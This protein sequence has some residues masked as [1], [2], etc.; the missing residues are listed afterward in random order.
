MQAYLVRRLFESALILL[1]ITLVTFIL[2]YLVPADPARQIAGRSA[3]AETVQNIRDQLGLNDPF[4][5][6][7]W[8]YLT[9]LLQ[10]DMG[11]SYLQRAEVS[12]LIASRLPASLLLMLAAIV[13][14][15]IFG[16]TIGIVAALRRNRPAD[17][18]LMIFS[19]VSISAPQFVIGILLLYV[20]AVKLGWFPIGG[21]GTFSHVVLPA[22][23]LGFL[24]A[25]WYSRM[26]RS[27]MID[28]LGQ[29]FVRTAQAKGLA[30]GRIILRHVIPNAILPIIAMIGIDIGLFMSGIV[31]VESVFG[32][33]GIGQL[34]WQAI[35]RVD[36]PVIMGVTMV[37]ATA[38]VLG[39]LLADFVAPMIDPRIK[40]K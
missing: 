32:W 7:Y 31:V 23:T 1:G 4:F 27:S 5:I 38:I 39:N 28:V 10:G 40:T 11:R 25:G 17:H 26:M 34:A 13:T 33:P 36:I 37:S 16:L 21:Y 35:Q 2:L 30:K 9:A 24:G 19:F 3:T 12:E 8:R 6:Q 20:F 14:E 22:I 15:L 18:G 29:D